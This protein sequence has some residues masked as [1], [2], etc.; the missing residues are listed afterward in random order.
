MDEDKIKEEIQT[1]LAERRL[2]ILSTMKGDQPYSRFMM[3]RNEGFR[4]Y[5]ISSKKTEKVQD[6]LNNPKVHI[7]LGFKTEGF[8]NP[9]LDITA[10]ATLEDEKELKDQLWHENFLKYLTG[11]DDPNYIVIRC[12]PKTIRLM[13]H[14]DLDGPYTLSFN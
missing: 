14:P 1:I 4:L 2:G 3:F 5:T 9:Y 8:G 11:P 6:I 12:E 10:M 7:L 13:S